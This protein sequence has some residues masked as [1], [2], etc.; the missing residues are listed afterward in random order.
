LLPIYNGYGN[1]KLFIE[2][3]NITENKPKTKVGIQ[4][5]RRSVGGKK[6]NNRRTRKKK[7]KFP[8]ISFGG[9]LI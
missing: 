3:L 2:S 5:R 6:R 8:Y 9:G 4:T 7:S 1:M